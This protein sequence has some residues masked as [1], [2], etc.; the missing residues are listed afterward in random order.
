[1]QNLKKV[2]VIGGDDICLILMKN[3]FLS[4]FLSPVW[5][6][7]TTARSVISYFERGEL[8]ELIFLEPMLPDMSYGQFLE[9]LNKLNIF[10]RSNVCIL[11]TCPQPRLE[12]LGSK[13]AII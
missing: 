9:T 12:T 3:I 6:H 7:I 13:Y 10:T 11:T 4:I 1:M 5:I 8:P 2:L